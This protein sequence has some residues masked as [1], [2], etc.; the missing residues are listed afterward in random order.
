MLPFDALPSLAELAV[1]FPAIG[2]GYV[3]LGWSASAPRSSPRRCWRIPC[4]CPA[5]CRCWRSWIALQP[6]PMASGS[7]TRWHAA[8]LCASC[9]SDDARQYRRRL[10]AAQH[11][12]A[13]DDGRAR[14]VPH[15]LRAVWTVWPAA[16]RTH[17][18]SV[19]HPSRVSG[20]VFSAMFGSGGF[21]Y[22]LYFSRAGRSRWCDASAL[23]RSRVSSPGPYSYADIAFYC[24]RCSVTVAA[25]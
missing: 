24:S 7:A 23:L 4:R 13:S 6:P 18:A 21:V 22:L 11:P 20:R 15:R 3:I 17:L 10:S 8:S 19:G 5:S 1:A 9:R 2:V 12:G 16:Q 25:P 14:A